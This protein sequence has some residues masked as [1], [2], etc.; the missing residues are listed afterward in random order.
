MRYSFLVVLALWGCVDGTASVVVYKDAPITRDPTLWPFASTS[1]WNMPVGSGAVLVPAN[2]KAVDGFWSGL[3]H[4]LTVTQDDPVRTVYNP[5]GNN[6]STPC[7]SLDELGSIRIPDNFVLSD[8]LN[9]NAGNAL[10][11]L[12]PDRRTVVEMAGL[13]RCVAGGP[14]YGYP[15][16]SH[17]LFGDGI[18]GGQGGAGLSALGGSLRGFEL[19]N[20]EPI[21][22]A[23][24]IG[25]PQSL[26]YYAAPGNP[27]SCYRWPAPRCDASYAAEGAAGY[28][29]TNPALTMG[30]LLVV[31]KS[32]EVSSRGFETTLG[33]RVFAAMRDYGA[34]TVG[35]SG[36]NVLLIEGEAAARPALFKLIDGTNGGWLRDLNRIMP[37]LQV[38]DNNGPGTVGGGGVP[39][40]PMAPEIVP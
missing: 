36:A 7:S 31:P 34:Y 24:K 13:A 16:G 40:A 5:N 21:R 30:S 3:N 4:I 35:S 18:E 27:K 22:H 14:V 11:I 19:E 39:L 20:D 37:L 17:D 32:A 15:A 6:G 9:N 26:Y 28:G 33:R 1:I 12:S 2:I 38:V 8:D 10:A 25:L 29:G 23:L